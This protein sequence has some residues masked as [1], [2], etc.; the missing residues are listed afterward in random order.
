M[1]EKAV[2]TVFS[3]LEGEWVGSGTLFDRPAE[4]TMTWEMVGAGFVRLS[5]TNALVGED[6]SRTPVLSSEA[7][8]RQRGSSAIGVWMDSRPQRILLAATLTDSTVTTTWTAEGET[9]RTEYTVRSPDVA[10]VRDYV[11]ADEGERL[12]AEATYAR[13]SIPPAR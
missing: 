4:F 7:T 12:F 6:G 5:F 10:V 13:R 8:Y 2:P 3:A 1:G 11:Y 9:G